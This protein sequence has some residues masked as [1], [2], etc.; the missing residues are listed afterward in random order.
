MSVQRGCVVIEAEPGKW[1][2]ITASREHDYDFVSATTTGP[3]CDAE[4]AFLSHEGANPGGSETV[5]HD[6]MTPYYRELLA[7][8][9]AEPKRRTYG[10]Y[11]TAGYR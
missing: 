6:Q 10:Y 7:R 2:C 5:N 8:F 3:E 11:G 1:Y 9:P 4:A